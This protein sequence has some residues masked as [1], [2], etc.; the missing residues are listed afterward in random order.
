MAVG[1]LREDE[2]ED[3]RLWRKGLLAKRNSL[4]TKIALMLHTS[5]IYLEN[6]EFKIF[7]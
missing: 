4:F 3:F 2:E 1:L 7:K 6:Y 5:I